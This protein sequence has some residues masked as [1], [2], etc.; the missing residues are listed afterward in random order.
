MLIRQDNLVNCGIRFWLNYY[1]S[2]LTIYF[3]VLCSRL[4]CP[5]FR[6]S[7]HCFCASEVTLKDISK[8][9]NRV[10][11]SIGVLVLCI[12]AKQLWL[13]M[14]PY[15]TRIS[16]TTSI[17]LSA[18]AMVN[19]IRIAW[20]YHGRCSFHF[21]AIPGRNRVWQ[22]HHITKLRSN[23]SISPF[24]NN[25]KQKITYLIIKFE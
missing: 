23:D 7:F 10:C 8:S 18:A 5:A 11:R 24:Y 14:H 22:F 9:V 16:P 3:L 19:T 20:K 21:P 17:H 13:Q 15:H 12:L 25:R 4:T 6:Q 1:I 2:A